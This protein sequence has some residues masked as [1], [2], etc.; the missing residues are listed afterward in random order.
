MVNLFQGKTTVFS[1]NSALMTISFN[2]TQVYVKLGLTLFIFFAF[3]TFL[4]FLPSIKFKPIPNKGIFMLALV[5]SVLT[6]FTFIMIF[7]LLFFPKEVNLEPESL[8]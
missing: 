7:Q 2:K 1:F 6:V 4:C 3:I 8:I 5:Y